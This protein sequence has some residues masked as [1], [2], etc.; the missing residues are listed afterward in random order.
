MADEQN[1]DGKKLQQINLD[2][3]AKNFM[4]S[5]QRQFDML[6]FNLAAHDTVQ[7]EAY[8][9][10]VNASKVMPAAQYHQNFEQLHAYA[11]DLLVRQIINDSL[12]ITLAAMNNAHFFLSL[13]KATD[14]NNKILPE[15]QKNA[16]ITQKD[17]IRA[18][19]D[20]KF[21]RL[22]KDYGIMCDLEDSITSLTFILKILVKQN[23]VVKK[24]QL[25]NRGKLLLELKS[26]ASIENEKP[27]TY[28]LDK[29][30]D[31]SKIY[32]END[33]VFFDDDELQSILITTAS[34]ADSL[35]KSVIEYARA[36]QKNK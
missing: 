32:R 5:L 1:P 29:L 14:A 26:V 30:V 33:I 17:F 20:E 34:F 21:N 7:E 6:A 12:N 10:R 11:R 22:E 27:V 35:F 28:Q 8:N 18:Q 3:V 9:Q 16:Q 23:K 25:D 4:L 24:E 19:L 15:A 31:V 2:Q 36:A 13:I